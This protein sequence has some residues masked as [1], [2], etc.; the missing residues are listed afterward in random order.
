MIRTVIAS[1]LALCAAGAFAQTGFQPSVSP[2]N[3]YS[4]HGTSTSSTIVFTNYGPGYVSNISTTFTYVSGV[5]TNGA[6]LYKEL[7]TCGGATVAPGG[8]CKVTIGF[9]DACPAAHGTALQYSLALTATSGQA[10]SV[11]VW[12]NSTGGVCY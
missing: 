9:D 12:G 4:G 3:M 2:D 5:R 6:R 11:P 8:T 10:V 1:A 7:D